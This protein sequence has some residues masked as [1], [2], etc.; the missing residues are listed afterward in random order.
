MHASKGLVE[1]DRA[2]QEPREWIPVWMPLGVFPLGG[3]NRRPSRRQVHLSARRAERTVTI[4]HGILV[5]TGHSAQVVRNASTCLTARSRAI[6]RLRDESSKSDSRN[7]SVS[8]ALSRQHLIRPLA[9]PSPSGYSGT[10]SP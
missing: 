4:C 8:S 1:D 5:H 7:P 3:F 2:C 9:T 10:G 6:Q